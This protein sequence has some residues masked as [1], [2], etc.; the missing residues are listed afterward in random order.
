M[1]I[2]NLYIADIDLARK[3]RSFLLKNINEKQKQIASSFKQEA[4]QDRSIISSYLKNILSEE[5]LSKNNNGKP[6]FE[7]GPYFNISHSGRYIVMAVS[8]SEVGVDIEENKNRD[9]SAL[10]RIF[11]EAEAKVIKEHQDFYYLWCA[12]ESL[13]KCMGST[14]G[15]VKEIPSLPLNGLKTFKGKDYQCHVFIFDNHIVS[16]TREGKEEYQVKTIKVEHLPLMIK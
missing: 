16:I 1:E 2:V 6:F 5:A 3:H 8:T 12:K 10:T 7:N 15:T 13:I 14:I 4:D 11:N 9:M